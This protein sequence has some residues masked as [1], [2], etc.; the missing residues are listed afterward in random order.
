VARQKLHD[1]A[2]ATLGFGSRRRQAT[3]DFARFGA[4]TMDWRIDDVF[5]FADGRTVVVV[6]MP[7]VVRQKLPASASIVR[8][9][10][11]VQKITV[12]SERMPSPGAPDRRAFET[13]D[14]VPQ[15]GLEGAQCWLRIENAP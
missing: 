11:E 9:N 12:K 10:A 14:D 6:E 13:W 8:G 4:M 7:T 5:R 3:D 2:R 1:S 15:E